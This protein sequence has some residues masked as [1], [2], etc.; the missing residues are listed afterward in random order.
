MDP[1]TIN[2][3][4]LQINVDTNNNSLPCHQAVNQCKCTGVKKHYLNSDSKTKNIPF[5][6]R[7]QMWPR[8]C[9]KGFGM[10]FKSQ[11]ELG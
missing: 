8:R 10:R 3:M 6:L 5:V 4:I 11:T 1:D 2:C 9:F 7:A